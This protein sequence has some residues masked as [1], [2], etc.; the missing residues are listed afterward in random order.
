MKNRQKVCMFD[1]C[2]NKHKI[3]TIL[4]FHY[5]PVIKK[6][7][8]VIVV[9][10]SKEVDMEAID[11]NKL[12]EAIAERLSRQVSVEVALWNVDECADY[13]KQARR[14]FSNK[15]SKNHS[16]PASINV[17]NGVGG[18]SQSCWYAHEVIQWVRDKGR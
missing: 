15:T 9:Q 14:T 6:D 5:I 17:P 10:N 16:F 1:T 13:L 12:A 7:R 4:P 8:D 2:I 11:Y 18:K 3:C